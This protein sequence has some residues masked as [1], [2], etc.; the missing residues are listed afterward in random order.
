VNLCRSPTSKINHE[1]AT[2]AETA[3]ITA[4]FKRAPPIFQATTPEWIEVFGQEE[5]VQAGAVAMKCS[6]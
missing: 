2:Q 3:K 6:R 5:I 4:E 1:A